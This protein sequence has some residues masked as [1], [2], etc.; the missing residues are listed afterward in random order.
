MDARGRNRDLAPLIA[1]RPELLGVGLDEG[2]A[3]VVR[4][5]AFTVIGRGRVLITDGADHAGQPFRGLRAGDRFDLARR[6]RLP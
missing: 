4:R 3:I 5:D 1:A 6:E 2:T